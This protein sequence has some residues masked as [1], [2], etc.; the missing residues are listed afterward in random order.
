MDLTDIIWVQLACADLQVAELQA[1][2]DTAS[3]SVWRFD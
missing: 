3:V 1:D 2:C